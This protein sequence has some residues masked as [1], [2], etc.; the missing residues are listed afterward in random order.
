MKIV[1]GQQLN[2]SQLQTINEIAL[3]CGVMFDTARLLFY[4][5]QDSVEKAKHFLN[6]NKSGFNDPLL[7]NGMSQAVN[8]ITQAKLLGHNV[9][10]FGDYDA[11]GVCA[12]TVL[13]NCLKD[14]GIDSVDAFVPERES[15]YG[16]SID[17]V[18]KFINEKNIQL[19][20]T[21]YCGISDYEI[22]NEIKRLGVDVV[23][24][25]HH[26]PPEIL[27]D[28]IKINPKI[29][30]Q[31]YPFDG[32]CGAGVA[33]KLGYALIGEKA[34]KYLDFVALATVADSMDLI[35]EN[36]DIVAEGLKL[37][38]NK[39][40][41]RLC[42]KYLIGDNSKIIT[43]QSLAYTVAPRVNAGGRM[44][45]A[46]CALQ[47]FIEQDPNKIFD[48]AVKLN[49]YN[50]QRQYMCD[51]IYH[52]AK[53]KIKKYALHKKS[54][55]LVKDQNWKAGFIGIVAARLVEEFGKPVIVFAGQDN[56]LKG[57]A[58][59]VD[60]INIHEAI[61]ANKDYLMGFGGHSQAAGVSISE[62]NFVA[63]DNALNLYIKEHYANVDT[64]QK[65]YVEWE[66]KDKF[67]MEFARQITL[68]EPFGVGNKS[69]LFATKI[70]E[71][72]ALPLKSNSPH[73]SFKTNSIDMLNFNGQKDLFSL[74][75]PIEKTIVFETNLSNFKNKEYLKGYVKAVCLDYSNMSSL[76]LNAF[77][78]QLDTII[79]EEDDF[80]TIDKSQVEIKNGFGT[81][82]VITNPENIKEYPQLCSLNRSF[83]SIQ[84]KN[85]ANELIYAPKEIVDGY[86]KVIYLDK[87]FSVQKSNAK[88]YVVKD[89][90][91]Y[92]IIDR[93]STDRSVFAQIFTYLKNLINKEVKSITQFALKNCGNF[94]VAQFIFV[95]RVFIELQIF[96]IK[97]GL[98]C[99]DEKVKNTLTNSKL[100]S[101]IIS[102]KDNYA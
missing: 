55:I 76:E 92:N 22:I 31:E 9:L 73:Y 48:L 91:G 44:G 35:D 43:A 41:L 61:T 89:Y 47:L 79:S 37:F 25:D 59:S 80:L 4:R 97:N 27:P 71:V 8:K 19:L 87:P 2:S 85:C 10:I 39:K 74:S 101:K 45:D 29:V 70:N 38:N 56:Y 50:T 11:D 67:S 36:R 16:L 81:L 42:M 83:A 82:Y 84:S 6:P 58:R 69:P 17:T 33:Y 86:E 21:V 93:I 34:D 96:S 88:N 26:E 98:L 20:I 100:Y 1:Y 75:L 57:S 60:A 3:S 95:L 5:K 99:Y 24:T 72:E 23:V 52:Q 51:E 66:I 13:Y 12:T 40:T 32:L 63:F 54:A 78:I 94:D 62:E 53:E 7:L 49:T 46:N 64:T 90:I 68:L 14:F 102:L 18:K 30:G 65:L 15:G 77:D 28:C